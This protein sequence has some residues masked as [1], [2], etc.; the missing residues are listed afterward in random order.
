MNNQ[1]NTD[2]K[3]ANTTTQNPTPLRCFTGSLISG[4]LAIAL[5]SLT[6]AI[7]QT[8][9]AKPIHSDNPAVINIA[10]AVRTLVVGITALGTGIFG[11][12]ALGLIGLAIQILIQQA[13]KKGSPS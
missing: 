13:T 12:V 4:G 5:Y 11:L 8:F 1:D 2:T 10:S 6:A 7:A 9:A 3:P